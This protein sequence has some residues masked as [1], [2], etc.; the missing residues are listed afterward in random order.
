[1][2]DSICVE[3][4]VKVYPDGSFWCALWGD[5]LVEGLSGFGRTPEK[6]VEELMKDDRAI[7]VIPHETYQ[8]TCPKCN[9]EQVSVAPYPLDADGLECSSCG[10]MIPI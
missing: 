2:T 1:M 9:H 4:P 6:A 3:N 7:A 5:D 10:F 8:L